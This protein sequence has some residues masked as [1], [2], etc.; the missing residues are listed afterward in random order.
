MTRPATWSPDP[1]AALARL[2]GRLFATVTEVSAVLSYDVQGRTV[3]KAIEAGEIPAT[4]AGTTWR[5]PVSWLREQVQLGAG[6]DD[7]AA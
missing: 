7:A 1:S 2:K 5:I 6:G 4:K 3:R